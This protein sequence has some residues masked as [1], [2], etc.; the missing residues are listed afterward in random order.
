MMIENLTDNQKKALRGELSPEQYE[1][2][3]MDLLQ[4][5]LV[6]LDPLID[7]PKA[8]QLTREGVEMALKLRNE[9]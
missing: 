5:G 9:Q 6:T 4:L 7:G 3:G 1:A 2:E 8:F